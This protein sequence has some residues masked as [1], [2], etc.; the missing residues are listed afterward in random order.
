MPK[1]F[2]CFPFFNELDL[3]EL[4]LNELADVVDYFVLAEA[5]TTYRGLPKPLM[6]KENRAR[7]ERF[8]PR[9]VHVVVDDMPVGGDAEPYRW[10]REGFQRRA[11]LR[12]LG[13]AHPRDFVI[14]SDV[15]EL[16]RP[17]AIERVAREAPMFPTRYRFE[18]KLYYYFL[19]LERLEPWSFAAMGRR[20]NLID[21]NQFRLFGK[22]WV[23]PRHQP[24]RLAKTIKYF[25]SPMRWRSIADAGW[26]FSYMNGPAAVCEKLFNYSHAMP[27][28]TNTLESARSKIAAALDDPI[29]AL[30]AVDVRFP[31]YLRRNLDRFAHM[32]ASELTTAGSSVAPRES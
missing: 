16:P 2:D 3:L 15:D 1:I 18:M 10:V 27:D 5:T 14:I 28:E 19:N 17:E 25:G 30:R 11:L 32:L 29:Y 8:L 12:G 6:F 7:F 22:P 9:I 24:K 20:A 23:T 13:A 4:R 26:H 21:A 31:E